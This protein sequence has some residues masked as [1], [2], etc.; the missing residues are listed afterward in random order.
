MSLS[1]KL[2]WVS[3]PVCIRGGIEDTLFDGGSDIIT[4]P[5]MLISFSGGMVVLSVA[6]G[7]GVTRGC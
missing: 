4:D 7:R 3:G 6:G 2:L 5:S 1:V